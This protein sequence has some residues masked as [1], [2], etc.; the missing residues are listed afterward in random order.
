MGYRQWGRTMQ[1]DLTD[2]TQW[3]IA[4]GV[5][6]A[7]RI[8]I[9][10]ASYGGYAALMGAARE[11][12]LYQ[13]AIGYVGVYDLP[14]MSSNPGWYNSDTSASY[15][16]RYLGAN[17]AELR[18]NSPANLA[19]RIKIPVFLI[20]GRDDK[21]APIVHSEKMREA[22]E[23]AGRPPEWMVG[24]REGHGFQ[25]EENRREL[26][27]RLL[28]FLEQHIGKGVP[29]NSAAPVAAASDD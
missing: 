27:T 11:P 20:A 17:Q 4:E 19:D 5:A 29:A 2:A 28:K 22:L 24:E 13:C 8:C 25:R 6:D 23:K 10:G 3:A 26:Y 16:S 9:Y 14:T 7:E 18:A 12:D 15:R 1:D 21:I